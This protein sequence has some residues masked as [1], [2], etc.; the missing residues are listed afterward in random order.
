[1]GRWAT[2]RREVARWLDRREVELGMGVRGKSTDLVL[3][4]WLVGCL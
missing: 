4:P 3:A 2:Y 1:M